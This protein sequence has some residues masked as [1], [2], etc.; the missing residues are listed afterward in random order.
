MGVY[1]KP[2][3][4]R[5]RYFTVEVSDGNGGTAISTVTVT[6]T[7]VND[8]PTVPDYS[9]NQRKYICIRKVV[10]TDVDG[11]KL[12]YSKISDPAN[13]KVEANADGTWTYNPKKGY[14]GTDSFKVEVSDE[15]VEQH[16]HNNYKNNT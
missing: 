5:N 3:L 10:G 11:D 15:M 1:S 6:V 13:G 9:Y 12:T 16:K 8:P 2:K 14:T 4:Y 7:P